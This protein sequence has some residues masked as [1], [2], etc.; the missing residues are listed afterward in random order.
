MESLFTVVQ[1]SDRKRL[2]FRQDPLRL[3]VTLGADLNLRDGVYGNSALHWA[4]LQGNH[5][6]LSLL[7]KL[8]ACVAVENKQARYCSFLCLLVANFKFINFL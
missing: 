6:S 5:S 8:G 2:F 7:L 1:Y 3:L 4:A